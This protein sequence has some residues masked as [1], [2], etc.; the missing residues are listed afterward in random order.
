MA[1]TKKTTTTAKKAPVKKAAAEKKT[2]A[3]KAVRRFRSHN[4]SDWCVMTPGWN[5]SSRLFV[6]VTTTPCGRFHS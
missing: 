3:K 4:I 6:D 5:P 2:T 1:T